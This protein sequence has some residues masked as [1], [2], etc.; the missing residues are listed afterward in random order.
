MIRAMDLGSSRG[1]DDIQNA[2]CQN[3]VLYTPLPQRPFCVYKDASN[4]G[5]GAVLTQETP[6][7]EQPVIL[8]SHKLSKAKRNYAVVEREALTI[9]WAID[10]VKCCLWGHKFTV[11]TNHTPLHWLNRMKDT[12]PRLM[13]W[14]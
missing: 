10:H 4:R 12:N 9:R 6:T 14:Y 1:F 2:I 13:R 7:G 8:L 3:A 5:L 11:V